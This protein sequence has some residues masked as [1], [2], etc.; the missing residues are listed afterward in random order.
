MH[1]LFGPLAFLP[2]VE[3]PY[4][5]VSGFGLTQCT[6]LSTIPL[7]TMLQNRLAESRTEDWRQG[8]QTM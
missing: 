1:M 5:A 7:A 8:K 6:L 2:A 3:A 4:I